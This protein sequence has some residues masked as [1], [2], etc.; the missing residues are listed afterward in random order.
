M[1]RLLPLLLLVVAVALPVHAAELAGVSMPDTTE[2]G[3]Q[4]L[5]LNGM[6]LRKKLFIKVYVA[7]LYLTEKAKD[8]AT[9]LSVD[10]PRHMEMHFLYDVGKNKLCDAWNE[11]LENNTPGASAQTKQGFATLCDL[12]ADMEDGE[13]MAYTYVPGEGTTV[14]I[15]GE[16]AGTIPGKEFADALFACW[17]GSSPPSADFRD[18]LLGG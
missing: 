18:G 1:R 7:G 13:R 4:T 14:T 15:R 2:I 5:V 17:I 8:A 16:A 6:G 10:G 12:M 11:G 3:G 9:I